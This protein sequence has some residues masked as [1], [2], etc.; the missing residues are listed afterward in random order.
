MCSLLRQKVRAR[1][2]DGQ[3]IQLTSSRFLTRLETVYVKA[4]VIIS[5]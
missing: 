5:N 1:L 2:T 4:C 3:A